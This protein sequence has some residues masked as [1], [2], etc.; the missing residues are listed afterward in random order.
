MTDLFKVSAYASALTQELAHDA[1]TLS[2]LSPPHIVLATTSGAVHSINIDTDE[3]STLGP[4]PGLT[5]VACSD[6]FLAYATSDKLVVYD[7]EQDQEHISTSVSNIRGIALLETQKYGNIRIFYSSESE[8]LEVTK[9]WIRVSSRVL[10]GD[11]RSPVELNSFRHVLSYGH[12]S[13]VEFYDLSLDTAIHSLPR[14][15]G[16]LFIRWQ[17]DSRVVVLQGTELT[18]LDLCTATAGSSSLET[19]SIDYLNQRLV[20]KLVEEPLSC[21]AFQLKSF[22]VLTKS[23]LLRFFDPDFEEI[24]SAASPMKGKLLCLRDSSLFLI[25]SH[26][27]SRVQPI[28]AEEKLK[29]LIDACRLTEAY[30]FAAKFGLPTDAIQEARLLQLLDSKA[31]AQAAEFAEQICQETVVKWTAWTAEFQRRGALE[32]LLPKLPYFM[33]PYD[34]LKELL[35]ELI[36]EQSQSILSTVQ[37]WPDCV[38]GSS[39]VLKSLAQDNLHEALALAYLKIGRE[40]DAFRSYLALGSKQAFNVLDDFDL[41]PR[42]LLEEGVVPKLFEVNPSAALELC[43][44][45]QEHLDIELILQCMPRKH[46]LDFLEDLDCPLLQEQQLDLII[47]E[48]PARLKGFLKHSEIDAE[49]ALQKVRER[50]LVEAEVYLLLHLQQ[51][52]AAMHILKTHFDLAC[53]YLTM[54]YDEGLWQSVLQQARLSPER[55]QQLLMYLQFHPKPITVYSLLSIGNEHFP[56][57]RNMIQDISH[58]VTLHLKASIAAKSELK[59]MRRQAVS[60]RH[61]GIGCESDSQCHVCNTSLEGTLRL[62]HCGHHTHATCMDLCNLC[63]TL[64]FPR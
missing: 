27:L 21:V 47:S 60:I 57:V 45:Y 39:E 2:D 43:K 3:A 31:Y 20:V 8:V 61:R 28:T 37:A 54:Q 41:A 12:S 17:N 59:A 11:L 19:Q 64:P 10:A 9:G 32:V 51:T 48:D 63:K 56:A 16:T 26:Q 14:K 29:G 35:L 23:G 46:A 58:L 7:L 4:F 53:E 62:R 42:A 6:K 25:G 18:V 49:V 13:A 52:E 55:T 36:H 24:Y 44:K 33:L 5:A 38:V 1:V 40:L 22:V 15:S 50:G 30:E 34:F